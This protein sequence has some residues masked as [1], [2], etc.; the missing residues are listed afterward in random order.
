[1][2]LVVVFLVV[3]RIRGIAVQIRPI[4]YLTSLISAAARLHGAPGEYQ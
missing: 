4:R 3:C 2:F 1:M